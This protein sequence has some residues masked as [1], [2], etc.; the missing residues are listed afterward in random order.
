MSWALYLRHEEADFSEWVAS[1]TDVHDA[2]FSQEKLERELWDS[3]DEEEDY[4]PVVVLV[5]EP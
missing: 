2:V 1:F 4:L 3:R 5:E